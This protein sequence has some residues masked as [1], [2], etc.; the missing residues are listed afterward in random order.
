MQVIEKPHKYNCI[1]TECQAK[2]KKDELKFAKSRLN[3]YKGQLTRPLGVDGEEGVGEG[4]RVWL[5]VVV[6]MRGEDWISG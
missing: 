1:C 3:A 2:A 6:R 4:Q 5:K